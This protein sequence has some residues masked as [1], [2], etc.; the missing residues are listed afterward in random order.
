MR[1]TRRG[2]TNLSQVHDPL[3]WCTWWLI[4]TWFSL[5]T[6]MKIISTIVILVLLTGFLGSASVK[7]RKGGRHSTAILELVSGMSMPGV[8]PHPHPGNHPE[9]VTLMHHHPA[10]HHR[11]GDHHYPNNHHDLDHHHEEAAVIAAAGLHT[12]SHAAHHHQEHYEGG[13]YGCPLFGFACT[14]HCRSFGHHSSYCGGPHLGRCI[15]T[16]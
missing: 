8:L 7:T 11:L 13:A 4:V 5:F 16:H 6:K 9:V 1:G 14:I 12:D 10:S 3:I 15:C 2:G